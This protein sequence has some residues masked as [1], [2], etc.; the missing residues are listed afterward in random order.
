MTATIAVQVAGVR[1]RAVAD[2]PIDVDGAFVRFESEGSADIEVH[3]RTGR[4]PSDRGERPVWDSRR[5]WR[6]SRRGSD[7]VFRVSGVTQRNPPPICVRLPGSGGPAEGIIDDEGPSVYNVLSM[8]LGP[9][10]L[11]GA[12]HE[13]GGALLHGCGVRVGRCAWAFP[14]RSG[15]GKTTLAGNLARISGV[16]VLSDDTLG[17]LP[18]KDGWLLCGTPW[19]GHPEYALADHG[20]LRGIGFLRKGARS[21]TS[22]ISQSEAIRRTLARLF[23]PWWIEDGAVRAMSLAAS[24]ASRVDARVATLTPTV[25]AAHF[26]IRAFACRESRRKPLPLA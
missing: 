17:L 4:L 22:P 3:V 18:T 9:V 20:P 11:M 1:L 26:L 10:L 5:G 7:L 6:V 8:P 24:I 13:R 12:L 21:T 16:R 2:R 14:A 23:V 19:S 15:G 25:A